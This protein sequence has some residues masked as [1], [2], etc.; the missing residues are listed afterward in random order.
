MNHVSLYGGAGKE[1]KPA[2]FRVLPTYVIPFFLHVYS[3]WC[4]Y[5]PVIPRVG[6]ITD[7]KEVRTWNGGPCTISSLLESDKPSRSV[8]LD[9]FRT[10]VLIFLYHRVEYTDHIF[11]HLHPLTTIME[12][13]YRL[14]PLADQVKIENQIK[15]TNTE[16]MSLEFCIGAHQLD[17][18]LIFSC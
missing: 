5:F 4:D 11:R 2:N 12:A 13:A 3:R 6:F 9:G 15:L 17:E 8:T 1:P 7:I 18:V 14:M 10:T 16:V